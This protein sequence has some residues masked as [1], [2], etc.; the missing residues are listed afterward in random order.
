[1]T[2]S[3]AYNKSIRFDRAPFFQKFEKMSLMFRLRKRVLD[4]FNSV[5]NCRWMKQKIYWQ[6][7]GFALSRSSNTDIIVHISCR[8]RIMISLKSM[9]SCLDAVWKQAGVFNKIS[10]GAYVTRQA[11]TQCVL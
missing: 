9:M 6:V 7:P 2:D 10:I 11:T 5:G 3:E 8:I 1:M 4:I